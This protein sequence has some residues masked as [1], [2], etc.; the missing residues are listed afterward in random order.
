VGEETAFAEGVS[1]ERDR[2]REREREREEMCRNSF[3]AKRAQCNYGP[4]LQ[5]Q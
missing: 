2:E 4:R 3:V 5:T 1:R